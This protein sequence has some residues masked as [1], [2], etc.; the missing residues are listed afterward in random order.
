MHVSISTIPDSGTIEGR[1]ADIEDE[2]LRSLP[3]NDKHG[4]SGGAMEWTKVTGDKAAT[5]AK[6]NFEVG[7]PMNVGL[8][9]NTFKERVSVSPNARSS[10][11]VKGK[12]E[13]VRNRATKLSFK[14]A[15]G[16]SGI[17]LLNISQNWS[18]HSI[19]GDG[20]LPNGHFQFAASG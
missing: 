12:K 5:E 17:H 19:N 11:S 16:N 4:H 9:T 18:S 7:G 3:H 10:A 15:A 8:E 20:E 13:V 1:G 2:R 6:G 14:S